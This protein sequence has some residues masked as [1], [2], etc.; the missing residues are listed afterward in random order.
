VTIHI[1][2]HIPW[3][4]KCVIKA[5]GCGASHKYTYTNLHYKI[6]KTFQKNIINHLYTY[7][8]SATD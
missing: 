3:I 2:T 6:L 8:N 5:V 1:Y 4:H 7:T